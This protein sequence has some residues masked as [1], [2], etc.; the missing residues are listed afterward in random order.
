MQ[1]VDHE[2][3]GLGRLQSERRSAAKR[4]AAGIADPD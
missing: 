1:F 2:T 4:A 3:Y